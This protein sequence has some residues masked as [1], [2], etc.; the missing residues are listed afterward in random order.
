MQ[1]NFLNWIQDVV[2]VSRRNSKRLGLV[3]NVEGLGIVSNW[4]SNVSGLGPPGLIYKST[5]IYF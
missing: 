2:L 3:K 4:K 5:N 1:Y